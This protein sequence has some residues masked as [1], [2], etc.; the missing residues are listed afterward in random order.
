MQPKL[1]G[2]SIAEMTI[3]DLANISPENISQ[4]LKTISVSKKAGIR[5]DVI[6]PNNYLF[7]PSTGNVGFV[8]LSVQTS[9]LLRNSLS[10]TGSNYDRTTAMSMQRQDYVYEA[11]SIVGTMYK[12]MLNDLAKNSSIFTK[13]ESAHIIEGALD[14]EGLV[15]TI[16]RMRITLQGN[17]DKIKI[18]KNFNKLTKSLTEGIKQELKLLGVSPLL[19]PL[20]IGEESGSKN[21]N[22]QQ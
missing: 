12:T 10:K 1:Q 6:N 8:D 18:L 17:S 5:L 9:P 15:N 11:R 14:G 3:D 16:D 22:E 2:K 13:K 20:I 4:L 19:V 21:G 7:N